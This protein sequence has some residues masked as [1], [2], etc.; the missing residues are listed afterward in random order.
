MKLSYFQSVFTCSKLTI[1]ILENGVKYVQNSKLTKKDTRTTSV[2]GIL[3]IHNDNHAII[4]YFLN[5]Y[6][7]CKIW[8]PEVFW[9]DKYFANFKRQLE[10][11]YNESVLKFRKLY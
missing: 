9:Q 1:E 7:V 3:L 4:K 8:H 11:A 5:N 10:Y 2:E 6:F